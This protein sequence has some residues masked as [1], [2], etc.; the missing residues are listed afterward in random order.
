MTTRKVG[1]F[2]SLEEAIEAQKK[3][4]DQGLKTTEPFH[5]N[6]FGLSR[7]W[8]EAEIEDDVS[9]VLNDVG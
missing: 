2:A 6:S 9:G 3:M 7:F 8:F 5:E 4:A 1:P